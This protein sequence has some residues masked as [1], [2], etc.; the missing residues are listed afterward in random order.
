[1]SI[2]LFGPL[3]KQRREE[4]GI[5]QEELA[6]GICSVPTLSRIENGERMPSK[7]HSE[8]LLQRLGYS[9]SIQISFVTEKTLEMHNLK[10]KN[11]QAVIH[12]RFEEAGELLKQFIAEADR[13]D[14]VSE[15]FIL[16]CQVQVSQLSPEER[17][18][19]LTKAMRMTCPQYSPAAIPEFLS[20]EEIVILNNI[21]LCYGD[22]GQLDMAINILSALKRHHENHMVNR[23]EIMRTQL[24]ILY[25]LSTF[26]GQAQ[27][28]DECIEICNQGIRISQET[29]R[30]NNLDKLYYNKAW[31]LV[32]RKR[33][34]DI[35]TA[36]ECIR[37]AICTAEALNRPALKKRFV[38]FMQSNFTD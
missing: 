25:N 8:M 18:E 11:R 29:R 30:C 28:Y 32:R 27:R 4:L 22:S 6:D 31:S 34:N 2:Y 20:Y 38:E 23:E 21:A 36:K 10:Y 17:L 5:S 35:L 37:L 16:L 9:D 13:G 3:I 26:L 12:R 15:Q 1:M 7:Q 14:C 24:M 19:Q 33:T